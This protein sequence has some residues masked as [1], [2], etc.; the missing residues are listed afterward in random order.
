[1]IL[2]GLSGCATTNGQMGGRTQEAVLELPPYTPTGKEPKVAVLVFE[3]N[4]FFESNVLGKF[5]SDMFETALVRSQRFMVIDRKGLLKLIEEKK[6]SM[7]G[8]T[9]ENAAT[10]GQMTGADYLVTGSITE[11]GIKRTGT[12]VTGGAVNLATLSGG[13]ATV[14]VEEG[15]ARMAI[16]VKITAV[17]TGQVVYMNSAVGQ[18][19]SGNVNLGLAMLTGGVAAVGGQIK[20]GTI[21]FDETIAGKAARAAAYRHVQTMVTDNAFHWQP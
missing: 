13:G 21:G 19:T 10:F 2:A 17:A 8:L 3:N 15:T 6:L 16:D 18:A 11:F 9:G 20:G 5:V 1:M 4:S 12:S 7:S 14:K